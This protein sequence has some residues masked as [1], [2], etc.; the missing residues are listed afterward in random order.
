[1]AYYCLQKGFELC[2]WKGL[3]FAL[4]Y[5]N[6]YF[7][8]F[9]DRES[10]RL[11]LKMDG[12][13]DITPD[14][15]TEKQKLLL[16]RLLE[17]KIV[18]RSEEASG[19]EPWQAYKSFPAMYKRSVQWSITGRCNYNCRHCFMNAPEYQG[20]DLTPEQ[21]AHILDELLSCGIRSIQLTGGEPMV[22][23]S[24]YEILDEIRK[25]NIR[26]DT[27]YSNGKLVDE[28]LLNELEKREMHPSFHLS[29]DGVGWH[30]WLRGVR[31]AEEEVI[32]AFRLLHEHGYE[33][34]TSMCLHRHNIGNLKA[35]VDLLASL[36]L[37]HIKMNVTLPTGRWKN[38]PEH[39]ITE[40]E[41]YEAVIAY[42]P[43]YVADGLPVSVQF[44]TFIDFN[45]EGR[46][47]MVP[48]KKYSGLPESGKEYTCGAIKT[49]M[50]ISPRGT[51]LPCMPMGGTAMEEKCDSVLE[52]PLQQILSE[53]YYHDLCFVK[54]GEC[55]EHNEKCR[56]C[57]YRLSCG[58]GCRACALGETGT[59]YRAI[60]DSACRF[61]RD[62]WYDKANAMADYYAQLLNFQKKSAAE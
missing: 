23:A 7:T 18:F 10:Y 52:K 56:Q 49:G 35:S 50:Y 27:I 48:N 37:G 24:F 21:I 47:I 13:H 39:F 32:R 19:L 44:G 25:R 59:D 15:L 30:D 41:M 1:M 5:P 20:K 60:D 8:D 3:P 12:K 14:S 43:Q 42:I 55:I 2:G 33:T 61:F 36:G 34:G 28:K 45:K 57:A 58:A 29:F 62:G 51:V 31:G 46:Y 54:M 17:E 26:V 53:S 4:R 9:F 16:D 22:H 11:V 38:E 6:P 40:E